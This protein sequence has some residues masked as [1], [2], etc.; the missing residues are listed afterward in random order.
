LP[1]SPV[2]SAHARATLTHGSLGRYRCLQ[3]A[4]DKLNDKASNVS[5]RAC[6]P[7]RHYCD[8]CDLNGRLSSTMPPRVTHPNTL[9][10]RSAVPSAGVHV[11]YLPHHLARVSVRCV[12]HD[13]Q[14]EM[15]PPARP[16]GVAGASEA[17]R[18]R[19]S[20][21]CVDEER[22]EKNEGPVSGWS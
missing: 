17:A 8:Q 10:A 7:L 22:G 4:L 15:R 14:E 19:G 2:R 6:P 21:L 1:P 12:Q 3:D 20:A 5:P 16:P 11:H 13:R 9:P 18:Q